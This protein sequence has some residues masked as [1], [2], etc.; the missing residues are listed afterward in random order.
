M[1]FFLIS[2]IGILAIASIAFAIDKEE[3]KEMFRGMSSDCKESEKATDADVELMVSE[4]YPESR[5]GKC[6]VA[7]MQ[8][9]FGIV[10][11][12]KFQKDVFLGLASI[13]I[14]E[15]EDNLKKAEAIAEECKDVTHE[16]RCERAILIGKC[17]EQGAK[18]RTLTL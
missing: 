7:C 16:D 12:N 1:K 4:K 5:E 3:A 14:G 10:Q 13:A 17:M 11:D 18:N 2:T 15:N 6:L 9:Q 8:E